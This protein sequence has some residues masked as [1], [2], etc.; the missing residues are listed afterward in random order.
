MVVD[1]HQ[2]AVELG[3]LVELQREDAVV[4]AVACR[5]RLTPRVAQDDLADATLLL[6][7]KNGV[8]VVGEDA[9][10]RIERLAVFA[11]RARGD[12]RLLGDSIRSASTLL[13]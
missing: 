9:G 13:L 4:G 3:E 8:P 5:L 1:V 12:G 7:A 2:R 10:V 11:V 6:V